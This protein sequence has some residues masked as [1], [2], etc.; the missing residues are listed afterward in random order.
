LSAQ[1]CDVRGHHR[2]SVMAIFIET[3]AVGEARETRVA[4]SG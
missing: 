2:M 1:C 3:V 4:H